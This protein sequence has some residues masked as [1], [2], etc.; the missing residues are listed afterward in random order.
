MCEEF[1]HALLVTG[2]LEVH[3]SH[4]AVWLSITIGSLEQHAQVMQRASIA[5][6]NVDDEARVSLL[7]DGHFAALFFG[8]DLDVG[9]RDLDFLLVKIGRDLDQCVSIFN[10]LDGVLDRLLNV[11]MEVIV[12]LIVV[13][14]NDHFGPLILRGSNSR[15]CIGHL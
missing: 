7:L 12:L 1:S 13:L 8:A 9:L 6:S 4:E 3:V 15:P 11:L 5:F 2:I 14:V 10:R